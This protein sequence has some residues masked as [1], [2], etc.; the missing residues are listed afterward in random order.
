MA[1]KNEAKVTFKAETD[2]FTDGIKAINTSIGAMNAQLKLNSAQLDGTSSDTE[3]LRSNIKLLADAQASAGQKVELTRMKLESAC[4][5]FGENSVEADRLRKSLALAELQEAN[6]GKKLDAASAALDAQESA[7]GQLSGTISQ[8]EGELEGLKR[9]YTN[10]VLEQGGESD[11]AK[12]LA[13]QITVLSKELEGNRATLREASD[14]ADQLTRSTDEVTQAAEEAEGGWT[15]M[16]GVLADLVSNGIQAGIGKLHDLASAV[17]ELPEATREYRTAMAKLDTAFSKANFSADVAAGTYRTLYRVV[18]DTDQATE[19]ANLIANMAKNQKELQQWTTILTGVFGTYGDS[20]P[21]ESL[22]ETAAETAKTGT[23][24]GSLADALNW[25]SEAATMFAGYMNKDVKTA[26]DAFNVALSQ[27]SNEQERQALITE[28]LTKLYGGAA[29]QYQETAGD[30]LDANDATARLTEVQSQMGEAMEPANTAWQN[31]KTTLMESFLPIAIERVQG[32]AGQIDALAGALSGVIGWCQEHQTL[33]TG[34]GIG[35]GVLTTAILAYN[36]S[37]HATAIASAVATAATGAFAAV[38]G[39]LTSPITIA[40]AIITALIAIGVALYQNWDTVSAAMG[41][42]MDFIGGKIEG[43]QQWFAGLW[44]SIQQVGTDMLATIG[45]AFDA[46]G[47]TLQ[48]VFDTIHTV[49]LNALDGIRSFL[50]STWF[51]WQDFQASL[52]NAWNSVKETTAAIWNGIKD[53]L[54]GVWIG[55]QTGVTN[56]V[57]AVKNTVSAIWNGIKSVTSTVWNGIKSCVTGVVGGIQNGVST[58]INAVKT[59]VSNIWHGIQSVTTTVWNGI[60]SGVVGVVTGVKTSVGNIFNGLKT[61]VT[62]IWNG[63]KSAIITPV[64]AAKDKVAGVIDK[65]KGLFHFSWSLPKLKVP[66]FGISPAGWKVGDL[67]KGSIPHL[68][69]RWAAKGGVMRNPTLFG[70]GEAGAEGILPLER[71]TWWMDK[72]ADIVTVRMAGQTQA[73]DYDRLQGLVRELVDG[74]TQP[75]YFKDREVG[76]MVR[77]VL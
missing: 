46:I 10:V 62:S 18:G 58:G 19:A 70:G 66:H 1:N 3:A 2:A 43:L 40:I 31:L 53:T 69:V 61:T 63:I 59:T 27:C 54:L 55:I 45:G 51:A 21:V 57:N 64:T 75:I 9:S 24:T 6:L 65:I 56:G 15:M 39:F 13:G 72:L 44:A 49:T 20:L 38:V 4:A 47:T 42:A 71:N 17:W 74:M 23:V 32:L 50:D 14:A 7:F 37:L 28:T 52:E 34:I 36:I 8:Q 25:S 76:R 35:L 29:E 16:K 5:I 67:L 73:I 11:A 12:E 22:A 30:I 48:G 41:S 33:L 60:K 77:E 26:E 68:S